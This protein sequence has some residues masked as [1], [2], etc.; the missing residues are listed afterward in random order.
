MT[1][2]PSF[3]PVAKA[4]SC[5]GTSALASAQEWTS[6][7]ICGSTCQFVQG[8]FTA[9]QPRFGLDSFDS[10]R[11]VVS[12]GFAVEVSYVPQDPQGSDAEMCLVWG[13]LGKYVTT[14]HFDPERSKS[15]PRP[16]QEAQPAPPWNYQYSQQPKFRLEYV[17][18]RRARSQGQGR[19][20]RR[21]SR[22]TRGRGQGHQGQHQQHVVP[23]QQVPLPAPPAVPYK[24]DGKGIASWNGQFP[25]GGLAPPPPPPLVATHGSVA[26]TNQPVAQ[27][28][29]VDPG[30]LSNAPG[31]EVPMVAPSQSPPSEAEIRL[32]SLLKEIKKAPEESLT[33][34]IQE[35]IK[36][37]AVREEE[38]V[39]KDMHR[40]VNGVKKARKA[41]ALA[42]SSRTKLLSDWRAFLQQ[43][44]TTWRE[45]MTL[46]EQQ[47]TALQRNLETAI[48]DLT[49]ARK[50]FQEQSETLK[51]QDANSGTDEEK[52]GDG[53]DDTMQVDA[54]KRIHEGIA[55]VVS[56]LQDLA[57]KTEIEEQKAKRQRRSIEVLDDAELEV[58]PALPSMQPFGQPGN[59]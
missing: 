8:A 11:N 57:E 31:A 33:P 9:S 18:W 50:K 48:K 3:A 51:E 27:A 28:Q 13:N 35:E 56:H 52:D 14:P 16:Y 36:K 6:S 25:A 37:N 39:T 43:S 32:Q 19:T 58:R 2:S 21:R 47:E 20:A 23:V 44:V 1:T 49:L 34:G 17:S 41:V 5:Q 15:V 55:T 12:E 26:M 59:K 53:Q 40:A 38:I 45:Y 7:T 24:G 4:F 46:F 30:R 54:T 42:T 29:C 10:Q 22:R